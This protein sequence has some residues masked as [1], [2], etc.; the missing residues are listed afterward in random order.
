MANLKEISETAFNQL[1]P[2]P[3]DETLVSRE[4]FLVTAKTEYAYF[5]WRK[6]KED[7]REYSES[8]IP[9]YLLSIAD[10]DI[11]DNQMDISDLKIMR[12]I[13]CEE[14]LQDIRP[15]DMS[16]CD[17]LYVKS[18]LNHNKILCDDDSLPENART[19]YPLGKKII[20]PQGT[21]ADKLRLI[22]A[23]NGEELDESI[24]VDDALGGLVR[25]ALIEIYA[26]KTGRE[27]KKDD[28]NA[29]VEV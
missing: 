8:D 6:I 7:K 25:R 27:D 4:Q 9:S 2:N 13:D 21:H 10:L 19:Y 16:V 1:F 24:E 3:G 11:A 12:S 22:Y 20:F 17:C 5:M 18:T 23:N 15:T 14:W 28:S 29:N 26:G